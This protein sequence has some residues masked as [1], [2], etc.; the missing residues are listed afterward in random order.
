MRK[1]FS[2]AL[3]IAMATLAASCGS[4]LPAIDPNVRLAYEKEQSEANI[5]NMAKAYSSLI[6]KTRKT[7][8]KLPGLYSDYAV[9]LAKKGKHAEAN[10][11][12]N[13]EIEAFP[14]SRTYV[15]QLKRELIPEFLDNMTISSDEA[16]EEENEALSAEARTAAEKKAASVMQESNEALE[17]EMTDQEENQGNREEESVSEES[18]DPENEGSQPKDSQEDTIQTIDE[19]NNDSPTDNGNEDG[20]DALH[21]EEE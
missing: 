18:I 10:N 1:L 6:N 13:K 5:D 19:G 14:S 11:W 17:S 16:P 4:S 21:P 2:A 12:F 15:M 7:G 20:E 8:T 9:A 3:L